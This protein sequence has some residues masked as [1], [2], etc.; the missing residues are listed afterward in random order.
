ME[1]FSRNV[2]ETFLKTPYYDGVEKSGFRNLFKFQR[3][4]SP[5]DAN[6]QQLDLNDLKNKSI[7]EFYSV[8]KV[9]KIPIIELHF[10]RLMA[11]WRGF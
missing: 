6:E 1:F 7:D 2:S 3:F 10:Q 8:I 4:R 5:F 11:Y 9:K